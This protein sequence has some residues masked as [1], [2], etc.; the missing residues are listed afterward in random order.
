MLSSFQLPLLLPC[1]NSFGSDC[2]LRKKSVL[3]TFPSYIRNYVEVK[4]LPD[5][6]LSE[7]ELIWFKKPVDKTKYSMNMLRYALLLR[8][9]SVQACKFLLQQFLLP[10]LSLL[11]NLLKG[12]LSHC[13]QQKF[14]WNK[15]EL[16][17]M[18]FCCLMEP[19]WWSLFTKRFMI[20][21]WETCWCLQRRKFVQR[22]YDIHD[23][24][25]KEVYPLCHKSCNWNKN[26]RK[27]AFKTHW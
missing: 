6:I 16:A 15:E 1:Q 20:P 3:E 4:K 12:E 24:Q 10:S 26:R 11:K 22:C 25:L 2:C 8:Y 19:A 17:L 5:D 9:I 7:L 23:K 13:K 27:M 14:Y 21:R 18:L